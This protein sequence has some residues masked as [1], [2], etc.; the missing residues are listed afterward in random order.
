MQYY[1]H[2]SLIH[3]FST[4]ASEATRYFRQSSLCRQKSS[5]S[6]I[7]VCIFTSAL[8]DLTHTTIN[9]GAYGG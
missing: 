3:M 8:R 2:W 4:S 6:V 5:I 7:S 1:M 9:P